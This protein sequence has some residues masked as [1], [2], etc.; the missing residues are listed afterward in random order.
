MPLDISLCERAPSNAFVS[1]M[2]NTESSLIL[3]RPCRAS[4]TPPGRV[5]LRAFS[6]QELDLNSVRFLG[7]RL[8]FAVGVLRGLL[9]TFFERAGVLRFG[10]G[11]LRGTRK[12][13]VGR[14]MVLAGSRPHNEIGSSSRR[15]Q[16]TAGWWGGLAA[17][18]I[19]ALVALRR[20][21]IRYPDFKI[22]NCPGWGLG[23]EQA[24]GIREGR[25][26]AGQGV[27]DGPALLLGG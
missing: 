8:F 26:I 21:P 22:G 12:F 13:E 23:S 10:M 14:R 25:R 1:R 24:E 27:D 5:R 9:G 2:I 16:R 6:Y 20:Y 17:Q 4:P 15:R 11:R 18:T 19:E 3:L 7:L